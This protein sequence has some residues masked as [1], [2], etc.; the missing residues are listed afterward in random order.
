MLLGGFASL[1]IRLLFVYSIRIG[2]SKSYE[3]FA[4][5]LHVFHSIRQ[6]I[7]ALYLV[8]VLFI[9]DL[10]FIVVIVILI[11]IFAQQSHNH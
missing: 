2:R 7:L 6:E 3:K 4:G 8:V 10:L 9:I 11:F 1:Q 5:R